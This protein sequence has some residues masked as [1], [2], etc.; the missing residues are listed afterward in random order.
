[1]FSM[2]LIL[3]LLYFTSACK[4]TKS[5]SFREKWEGGLGYLKREDFQSQ[6]C[7]KQ[8]RSLINIGH[9][10]GPVC[11]LYANSCL[12]TWLKAIYISAH[13]MTHLFPSLLTIHESCC[14]QSSPS[15]SEASLLFPCSVWPPQWAM[16][17]LTPIA[18]PS[19]TL[20]LRQTDGHW[21]TFSLWAPYKVKFCTK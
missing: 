13:M 18:P 5:L 19:S 7:L 14:V 9:H 2:E 10:W 3:V 4:N 11:V 1:M 15:L 21:P 6:K 8:E 12:M 17:F 20:K 16:H